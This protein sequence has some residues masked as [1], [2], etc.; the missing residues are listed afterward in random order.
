MRYRERTQQYQALRERDLQLGESEE[1]FRRVFETSSDA[2]IITR[3]IDGH[4]IDVNRE[5]LNR[6]GYGHDEVIGRIPSELDL[7]D[8]R[9]QA[10]LLSD[11]IK[12][13]GF[14]RNVEGHFRMRSGESVTALISSVRAMI[15]GEECVIS[16]V[17]DVTELRKAHEALVAAR[18]VALRGLRSQI[19]ISL[20]HVARDPHSAQRHPGL[21]RS[22]HRHSPR[23]SSAITSTA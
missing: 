1:K 22:A 16:A 3:T 8:D 17:R 20:L 15:N 6:T 21:G 23:P 14:A 19:T 10:K 13:T 18:E 9:A 12:A 7:W 2:I 4:I 5:F 11:E